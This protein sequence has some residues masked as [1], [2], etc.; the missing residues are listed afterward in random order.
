M[1]PVSTGMS[2]TDGGMECSLDALDLRSRLLLSLGREVDSTL[3]SATARWPSCRPDNGRSG[4][5]LDVASGAWPRDV[6]VADAAIARHGRP[7]RTQLV[8]RSSSLAEG[9]H[10]AFSF[11]HD[12]RSVK[13]SRVC[14]EIPVPNLGLPYYRRWM[15]DSSRVCCLSRAY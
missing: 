6:G 5:P 11:R 8:Q 2:I 4:V 12:A 13:V 7:W 3:L 10:L 15:L 9:V 14:L 1:T